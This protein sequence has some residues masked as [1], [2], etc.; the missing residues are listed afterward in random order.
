LTEPRQYGLGRRTEHD[1]RSRAFHVA[2]WP[3]TRIKSQR[4]TR[5]VPIFDQGALG[6]CTGHAAAGW[7][8]T[9]NVARPG[10][11]EWIAGKPVDEMFAVELY[12]R[13]TH[14]DQWPGVYP[15]D[16][17]G[18]SGLAVAK[19][20]RE[21]R[22]CR[23]YSHAFSLRGTFTA[24]QT[25]PALIGIPWYDDMFDPDPDG[26]VNV[27]GELAGGHELVVDELDVGNM[28]LWF[29]NSW[30]EGWG[31]GGRAWLDW[32]DF[33]RLRKDDGD[34]TVPRL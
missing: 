13:A 22:L 8:G 16:D 19:A 33:D 11:T 15:P 23:A 24:L 3:W 4:W 2:A 32:D 27:G 9:D 17:S 1:E 29:T 25:G 34:V 26:R 30:G 12:S 5:R 20:L 31:I 6:S 21:D 7:V 28:R 18:S 10:L 14:L